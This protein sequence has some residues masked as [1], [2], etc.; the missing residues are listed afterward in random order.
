VG[1]PISETGGKVR[2][3]LDSMGSGGMTRAARLRW[4]YPIPIGRPELGRTMVSGRRPVLVPPNVP[5]DCGRWASGDGACFGPVSYRPR[6][7]TCIDG[8]SGCS[9][10]R[11]T[12][13]LGPDDHGPR[14]R[15][16]LALP[17]RASRTH[18]SPIT[19]ASAPTGVKPLF[20]PHQ[21]R[22]S[23]TL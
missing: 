1:T 2:T 23:R 20:L 14:P 6:G 21:H 17:Y 8:T 16:L 12:H 13:G 3:M 18:R 22:S 9:G 15:N 5:P 4:A 19:P 10:G 7:M 11:L